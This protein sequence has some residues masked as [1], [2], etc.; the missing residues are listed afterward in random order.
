MTRCRML[1][2][3]FRAGKIRNG[4]RNGVINSPQL[5]RRASRWCEAVKITSEIGSG[6]LS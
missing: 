3:L 4:E 5:G 2:D 6:V 1:H